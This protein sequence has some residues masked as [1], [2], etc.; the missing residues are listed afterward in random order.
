MTPGH[1]GLME[2]LGLL[3]GSGEVIRI[4]V[5]FCRVGG[6]LMLL[7]G[8]GSVFV[9]PRARLLFAVSVALMLA[10]AVPPAG[11]DIRA[12]AGFPGIAWACLSELAV[13]VSM[14]LVGRMIIAMIEFLAT[15]ASTG[16]GM[17]NPFG[18]ALEQGEVLPPLAT[19]ISVCASAMVFAA[20]L[21]LQALV[22][23]LESYTVAPLAGFTRP[24]FALDQLAR[25]LGLASHAALRVFSPFIVY[26]ILVNFS[27][28]LINRLT[29]Q[30]AVFY[31]STPFVVAG[32]L[33]ILNESLNGLLA[34]ISAILR[35]W[36][37]NG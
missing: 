22:G 28:S 12:D 4:F 32:G 34:E 36:L 37:A 18:L 20:D 17:A 15:V 5:V 25:S 30:I 14:G 1:A 33:W 10:P 24:G 19:F 3:I 21:H 8:L 35:L 31:V 6:C 11:F 27:I 16:I 23:I 9:P 13:G 29:P 2:N 7:P 26:A